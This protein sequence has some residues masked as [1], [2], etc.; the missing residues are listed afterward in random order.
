MLEAKLPVDL[1]ALRAGR[2]LALHTRDA[3]QGRHA[4]SLDV[5]LVHGSCASMLQWSA[6]IDALAE[7]HNVVAYDAYGCGR[8]PKP[9]DWHAYSAAQHVEDLKAVVRRCSGDA[10]RRRRRR[11]VIVAHSA[12]CSWALQAALDEPVAIDGLVLLGG[13]DAKPEAASHPIFRFPVRCLEGI[14]PLLSARLGARALHPRARA[15]ASREHR[16]LMELCAETNRSNSMYMCKVRPRQDSRS[17]A[18]R[19][20]SFSDTVILT[21]HVP[22]PA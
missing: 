18:L 5:V 8:S 22:P 9:N 12:A 14:Q 16:E 4:A 15:G 2:N 6:Q 19:G 17:C 1:V 10:R 13:L 20:C 3:Q 11:T 21:R 7:R